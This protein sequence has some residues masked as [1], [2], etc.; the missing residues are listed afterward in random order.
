MTD[1]P[2]VLGTFRQPMVTSIGIILGFVLG[3]FGKWAL[4]TPEAP[5]DGSDTV[6]CSGLT[7]GSAL[8]IFAL[9]RMLRYDYPRET[10]LPYYRT[11][12][13]LFISGLS[14]ALLGCIVAVLQNVG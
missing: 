10:P 12:L 3:F 2:D 8:M 11:T 9:F 5:W 4:E 7:A 13:Q 1:Q 6:V 14:T